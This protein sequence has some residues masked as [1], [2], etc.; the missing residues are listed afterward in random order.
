M[1]RDSVV[2]CALLTMWAAAA[3]VYAQ[4]TDR[5][6]ARII[7]GRLEATLTSEARRYCHVLRFPDRWRIQKYDRNGQPLFI[8]ESTD[9]EFRVQGLLGTRFLVGAFQTLVF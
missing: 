3:N 2:L 8:D 9:Y 4:S 6:L 5:G 1:R 7:G